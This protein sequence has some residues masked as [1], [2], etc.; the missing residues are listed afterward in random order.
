MAFLGGLGLLL[1]H[2][3]AVLYV[4]MVY[5]G[6]FIAPTWP[7]IQTYAV[8]RLG[9]DPTIVMVFLSCLGILGYSLANFIMGIIGDMSGLRMS[10]IVAPSSIFFLLL[11]IL[12]EKQFKK[13]TFRP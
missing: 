2:R 7:S 8:R 5:M 6:F 3:L 11:L 10:F 13:E 9:A 4:L 12:A 1:V